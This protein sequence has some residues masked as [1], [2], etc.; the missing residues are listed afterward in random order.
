ML[1]VQETQSAKRRET[2]L[3]A[4]KEF[5]KTQINCATCT[6]KCCT[7]VANSMQCSP[8]ESLEIFNW[9]ND[10]KLWDDNMILK[11]KTCISDYRLDYE[12]PTTRGV[13]LRRTYTCP[14][15]NHG[16]LGCLLKPEIKPYGCL[17]FN[18][19]SQKVSDGENCASNTD[20]LEQRDQLWSEFEEDQN[21]KLKKSLNLYWDKLP[22][23]IA[24][25]DVMERLDKRSSEA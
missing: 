19:L 12:I 25:L 1:E 13:P 9:L 24:L 10:E 6:G 16:P 15:F 8:I 2:L 5:D 21:S 11:L 14:F 17:A 22:M 7:S 23:P 3:S 18:P 4:M 20:L